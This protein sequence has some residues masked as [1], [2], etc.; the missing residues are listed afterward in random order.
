LQADHLYL[1][2]P[3][4][5]LFVEGGWLRVRAVDLKQRRFPV[6]VLFESMAH[7]YGDAAAAVVL[8]GSGSDGS[9]GIRAIKAAGG[10]VFVQDPGSARFDSMPQNALMT[11]VV[12]Q[13]ASPPELAR[14]LV[15]FARSE[16]LSF[17]S[18]VD[19]S[20]E[21]LSRTLAAV[22]RATGADFRGYKLATL[23]RRIHRRMVLSGRPRSE[24]YAALV[25]SSNEEASTLSRQLLVGVTSFFRDKEAFADV[26][27]AV[28]APL[29]TQSPPDR[30]IRVWVPACSTGEEVYSLA[31]LFLEEMRLQSR[32]CDLRVFGTDIDKAAIRRASIGRY[33]Q[34]AVADLN[35]ETVARYFELNGDHLVVRTSVRRHVLFS[36]HDVFRAPPFTRIDLVSCRNLFIYVGEQLQRAALERFHF[37]LQEDGSLF[38]GASET[39]AAMRGSFETI[40]ARTRLYRPIG[41][42]RPPSHASEGFALPSPV[43]LVQPQREPHAAVLSDAALAA[44][45]SGFANAAVVVDGQLRI[46]R[47]Y[48]DVAPYFYV[49]DG[50]P[51]VDLVELSGP[52]GGAALAVAIQ[53]SLRDR[54]A[55]RL[56]A[57]SF[58]GTPDQVTAATVIPLDGGAS[59]FALVALSPANH[60][61]TPETAR[62]DDLQALHSELIRSREHAAIT[63]EQLQASNEELQSTNE[64]LVS[65]NE[66]LQATNE[67]LQATGE[68]LRSVNAEL[69]N[70]VEEQLR[71]QADL[72]NFLRVSGVATLFLDHELRLRRFTPAVTRYLQLLPSDL[73]R[74]I[75][76]FALE[77]AGVDLS[78]LKAAVRVGLS[79]ERRVTTPLGTETLVRITPYDR[80]SWRPLRNGAETPT[81]PGAVVTFVDVTEMAQAS[82]RLQRVIDGL[83]YQIALLSR[84]G[85]I[86]MVNLQWRRF[87]LENGGADETCGEGARYLEVWKAAPDSA[88]FVERM[89]DVLERAAALELEYPCHS[90]TEE[91]WFLMQARGLEGGGAVVA[92]LDITMRKVAERQLSTLAFT[93][94]LTGALNRR[95]GDRALAD[96]ISRRRRTQDPIGA[97]L[98]DCDS[99]KAINDKLGYTMGDSVLRLIAQRI[100]EPP[101]NRCAHSFGRR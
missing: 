95:G 17:P 44:M 58:G 80:A 2:S 100:R 68:E 46:Q 67:E 78:A 91:R 24:D 53:R 74:T 70:S 83:P 98:I 39:V 87:M 88:S 76:H 6:D 64:E 69:K 54:E 93:D 85:R 51:T 48:G 84:E 12:D 96:L 99:F 41:P 73:G 18:T 97:V 32:R 5:E 66:E 37:S 3:G 92:H 9:R 20:G 23:Q 19:F 30:E 59:G 4:L 8:S 63:L 50:K 36:H 61:D 7:S 31:I 55:S 15:A 56:P 21:P 47:S 14:H 60:S 77:P 49:R 43:D 72:D 45:V 82:R 13:M 42:K 29:V 28:I 86:E 101:R 65:S 33:V 16:V 38:L 1:I 26:R 89:H 52:A 90:P 27:S 34:A 11:G 71:L 81:D 40:A 22:R 94:P 25:E 79:S 35:P 75:E 62:L 10:A 57:V